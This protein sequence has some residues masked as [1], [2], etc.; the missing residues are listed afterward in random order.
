MNNGWGGTE[1]EHRVVGLLLFLAASDAGFVNA[2]DY[3][4]RD[5]SR[6]GEASDT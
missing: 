5:R 3:Y 6:L 2:G 1:D 4:D